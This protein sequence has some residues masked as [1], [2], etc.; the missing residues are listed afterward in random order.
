MTRRL[1]WLSVVFLVAPATAHAQWQGFVD[2][3]DPLRTDRFSFGGTNAEA[4]DTNENYYDGDFGD[5]DGDGRLDRGTISRYGLLWNLGGGVM[6]PAADT[7][8]G[9]TYQF[10]D[11]D[12]IGNDAVIWADVDTDGDVDSVMGGNGEPFTVQTNRAARFAIKAKYGNSSAKRI[13]K[14]DLER[15]GDVDLIVAGVFCLT[16]NCGQPDDFTVWV[17]DGTGTFTDETVARGLDYRTA[18]IAGV[19]AG[20]IDGD[21]D[22]DLVMMSGGRRRALAAINDGSGNFTERAFFTIPDALWTYQTGGEPTV[23]MSGADNT[24]LGDLDN[25]GD[26]DFVVGVF[27]PVGGHPNVFYPLFINDGAGNFTEQAATRFDVGA[28]TGK[29]YATDIK[30]GDFDHDGDL[31]I[32]GYAQ[33][34]LADMQGQKLHLLLNDGTG[35]FTFTPGK[36]PAFTPPTG[37]INAFDVADYTGDG[38]IDLWVGNQGGRVLA[39]VNTYAD[40]SGVP[41]DA[42]RDAS[43][44]SATPTGVR[45]SWR[46]PPSASQ[47][48]Y[49]R[50]YRSTTPGLPIEDRTLVKTIARSVHADD[51]FVAPVTKSTTVAQLGDPQVMID[52]ADGRLEWTDTTAVPGV[53]YQYSVVHVGNETKPSAPTPELAAMIPP[54]AGGDTTPPELVI[55]SPT[56]Q[57]WSAFPRVVLQYADGQ[58]GVDPASLR[59]SFSAALGNPAAGGR[60]ANTDVSDLAVWKDARVAVAAFGPPYALPA[61]TLV[62][63]T[64]TIRDVAGNEATKT[65]QFFVATTS[66]QPPTAAFTATPQSG[67]APIDVMFDATSSTDPDGRIVRYEWYFGDGAMATGAIV[68]HRYNFGGTFTATLVVRDTQGG[69]GVMARTI[70]TTGAMPECMN[71]EV[72][73]CYSGDPSTQGVGRCVAGLETCGE[74]VWAQTC[75]G[76]IAPA[77][78]VCDDGVD[79][80]CDGL[81]DA[82]DPDCGGAGTPDAG[83]CGC[84]SSAP[85][86]FALL[87]LLVALCRPRRSRC[88]VD[89]AT[90]S[91]EH[92][93]NKWR[94]R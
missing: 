89:G 65:V 64:A 35:R 70:T 91:L 31:D 90:A 46:P 54:P 5:V 94:K 92:R 48:R 55:A 76:E 23:G 22:F 3:S 87:L 36:T 11:K 80:D 71:G 85:G 49:Y 63:M 16:R 38:S 9:A 84:Q 59:L 86:P 51:G 73:A 2:Q 17:N 50:I 67:D 45:L 28:F 88:N 56:M 30:L 93:R 58:S 66:P 13:V 68:S 37:G 8:N 61:N 14:I 72:R 79:G 26:L 12:A 69:V 74:G 39:F 81:D 32:A 27:G 53:V 44:V 43:V 75:A 34:G 47:V 19:S 33:S 57:H 29:L 41:A 7:I 60:A 18:L 4:G 15:D 25:D 83:G 78:E 6:L 77:A 1:S 82:A 42:P 21:G 62:T 10:G 52:P 20:D 24:A 40:A